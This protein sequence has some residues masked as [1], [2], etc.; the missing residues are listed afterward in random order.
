MITQFEIGYFQDTTDGVGAAS[1][2]AGHYQSLEPVP[3]VAIPCCGIQPFIRESPPL[4]TVHQPTPE[5]EN[6]VG[7]I[8][9]EETILKV[10]TNQKSIVSQAL[11][12]LA[13]IQKEVTVDSL[14]ETEICQILM[15]NVRPAYNA[16]TVEGKL[17]RR[18]LKH[19]QKICRRDPNFNNEDLPDV[20]DVTDS[21]AENP[22]PVRSFRGLFGYQSN[23]TNNSQSIILAG[24]NRTENSIMYDVQ[25]PNQIASSTTVKSKSAAAEQSNPGRPIMSLPSEDSSSSVTLTPPPPVSPARKYPPSKRGRGR[26]RKDRDS[27]SVSAARSP[28]KKSNAGR[29]RPFKK[30]WARG[31]PSKQ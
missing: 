16:D 2:K 24:S 13:D 30:K 26:P 3:G 12:R 17:C 23:S 5:R 15:N 31:R 14:F 7:L 29:G 11:R 8:K 4:I 18:L 19:F 6:V 10:L 9:N 1:S 25:T 20:T 28:V 21:E 22:P 27:L